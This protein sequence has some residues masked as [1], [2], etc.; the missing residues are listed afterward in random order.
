MEIDQ[1]TFYKLVVEK[2]TV[3]LNELQARCILLETQ[4]QLALE[5]NEQLTNDAAKINKKEKKS[6]FTN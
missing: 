1:S 3:K 6:E 5:A 2:T 4:L